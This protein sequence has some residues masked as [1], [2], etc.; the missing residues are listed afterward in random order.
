MTETEARVLL[1]Q[2]MMRANADATT[3]VL[4]G[5]SEAS[6]RFANNAITQN[7][8]K[9]NTTLTVTSAYDNRVGV[10]RI[11]QLN[12]DAIGDAIRRAEEIARNAAPNTEYM[13]PIE[14]CVVPQVPAWDEATAAADPQ[15]R[16]DAIVTAIRAA[17]R[18]G[19]NAAGSFATEAGFTAFL[20]SRGMFAYHRMTEARLVCTAMTDNSSGWAE[21]ISHAVADVDPN[22]VADR[23]VGKAVTARNP[24]DM[25]ARPYT[26]ILEPAALAEMLA[27]FAWSLDAKAADEGRSALSGKLGQRIGVDGLTILSDPTHPQ[28]PGLPF[29]EDG[30]PTPTVRWVDKGMLANLSHSRYWS[31]KAGRPFTGQPTNLIMEGTDT[32]LQRLIA[33]TSAGLLVTRFWYIRFVDPMKLLLTGMTRDG[34]FEIR[35]GEIVGGVKNMRFNESPLRM[36]QNIVAIGKPE[37]ASGYGRGYVPAVKVDNFNFSSATAF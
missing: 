2:A 35:D 1:E 25:E 36:F 21:G 15:L 27:F 4:S 20:N 14:P 33:Q 28:C 19:T 10:S 26:V 18:A 37:T 12:P 29:I 32:P 16:A 13:P 31:Q 30:M 17:E 6:T 23:A 5:S 7:V 3:L 9:T 34:L 11:N 24:R 8:A 22:A